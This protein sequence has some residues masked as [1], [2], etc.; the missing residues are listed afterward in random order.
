[1]KN[2]S[3]SKTIITLL[4]ICFC[5]SSFAQLASK[6]QNTWWKLEDNR[7][8]AWNCFLPGGKLKVTFSDKSQPDHEATWKD[9]GKNKILMK[10]IEYEIIS[11]D[12]KKLVMKS[13]GMNLTFLN[14]GKYTS[15]KKAPTVVKATSSYK[16]GDKVQVLWQEKWYPATI[17]EVINGKYK[18]HYDGWEAK[19]DEVVDVKR[20]KK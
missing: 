7:F 15:A 11:V 2:I 5:Q 1:M 10:T 4:L 19:W 12:A 3:V 18:I 9:L 17:L 8:K 20:M 14:M 16:V 13:S 6:I